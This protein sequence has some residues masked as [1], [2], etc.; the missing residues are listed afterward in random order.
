MS[1]RQDVLERY[2]DQR[3]RLVTIFTDGHKVG[4]VFH[5]RRGDE[6]IVLK[7]GQNPSEEDEI[8]ENQAVHAF[9]VAMGIGWF[10]PNVITYQPG[11]GCSYLVVEYAGVPFVRGI[12][13]CRSKRLYYYTLLATLKNAYAESAMH[14]GGPA[15]QQLLF[16]VQKCI[17]QLQQHLS[18]LSDSELLVRQ[19]MQVSGWIKTS[20]FPVSTFSQWDFTPED[21]YLGEDGCWRVNDL[22]TPVRG[23]PIIDLATFTGT[24]L[25]HDLSLSDWA[26]EVYREAAQNEVADIC[27]INSET[28]LRVFNLGRILQLLLSTRFRRASD[29]G[30]ADRLYREATMLIGQ[31]VS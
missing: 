25:A 2:L 7:V 28:A 3:W 18:D 11:D 20:S 9:M 30:Q 12:E 6:Q 21:T 16:V 26:F 4:E 24:C 15:Q 29:P 19:L 31:V 23:L 17:T 27:E 10:H 1:Y 8:Y 14:G 5:L 13:S 22:R